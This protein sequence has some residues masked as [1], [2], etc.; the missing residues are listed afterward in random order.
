MVG[1]GWKVGLSAISLPDPISQTPKLMEN[2]DEMF[3]SAWIAVG[4]IGSHA[5]FDFSAEFQPSDL[6]N[7]DL[8]TLTGVGFMK[9]VKSFF[10]KQRVEKALTIGFKFA[11]GGKK[12]Y[13]PMKWEGEDLVIDNSNVLLQKLAATATSI[14][15]FTSTR[16]L[17]WKWD[18][19]KRGVTSM[20][21]LPIWSLK[22]R[23]T[24][25]QPPQTRLACQNPIVSGKRLRM[26]K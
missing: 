9:T 23:M 11:S 20:I 1:H 21:C 4:T 3:K 25:F 5:K 8:V 12:T 18:G 10:D 26:E 13:S 22:S 14:P 24:L 15:L 16:T 2:N 6:R 7:E 19:S 17:C